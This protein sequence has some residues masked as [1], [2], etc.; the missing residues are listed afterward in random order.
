MK[1]FKLWSVVMAFVFLGLAAS[2]TPVRLR[3]EYLE[4][5]LGIDIVAPQLAPRMGT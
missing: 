1:R 2:A 3:C 5:P 4:N